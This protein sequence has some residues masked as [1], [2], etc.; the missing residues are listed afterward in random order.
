MS[1]QIRHAVIL[2][3]G[4]GQRMMPLTEN[5][6]KPLLSIAG[7]ALLE[8]IICGLRDAGISEVVI[9]LGY[10][11]HMI[12]T[13]FG[14]GERYGIKLTYC[15][16]QTQNGTAGALLAAEGLCGDTPF[17]LHWGD[18][19]ISPENYPHLL[20]A[21]AAV[22]PPPAALLGANWTEDPKD[23]AAIYQQGDRVTAIV[24]KPPA[25]TA[26]T[27]WNNAGVMALG[28]K[29]WSALHALTPSPRGEYEFTDAIRTLLRQGENVRAFHLSGFWSDVGTPEIV[30]ELSAH[31]PFPFNSTIN[32]GM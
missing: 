8:Y 12:E 28:T 20:T 5:C 19:L 13:Y 24:E 32:R 23:G 1:Q 15:R 18:I 2:A 25:G 10:L 26:T 14:R 16:Q 31:P 29:I 4:R 30:H 22:T 9:V 21:Y 7:H 27:N 11:G 6:P 17:V 3:A